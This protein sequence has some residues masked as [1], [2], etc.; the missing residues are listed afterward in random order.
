MPPT[1]ARRGPFPIQH[2]CVL[3]FAADT[4]LD[5]Q[6]LAGRVEHVASGQASRFE[7]MEGL[8]AF[9]IQV[10]QTLAS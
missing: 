6:G 1:P 8:V 7:S 4:G 10:L 5:A 3:Q 2:A 9:V